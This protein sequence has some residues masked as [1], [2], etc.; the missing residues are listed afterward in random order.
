NLVYAGLALPLG[1]ISDRVGRRRLIFASYLLYAA[2]VALI[3]WSGAPAVAVLALGLLGVQSA[4]TQGAHRRP[5]AG[6]PSPR[7]RGPAFGVYHSAVGT[8]L[9]P[10]SVLAGALWDRVGP[11]AAFVTDAALAAVAALMFALLLPARD[12]QKDR[13]R[14][15]ST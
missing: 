5:V 9:L 6:P 7:R 8:A 10:A 12:E 13:W 4:L 15:E 14:V 1:A 11:R 2:T 3:G